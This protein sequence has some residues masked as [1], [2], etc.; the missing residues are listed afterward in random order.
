MTK[1]MKPLGP[2]MGPDSMAWSEGNATTETA[3]L[4]YLGV[5]MVGRKPRG[6]KK[7]TEK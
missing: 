2:K 5:V 6:H 4:G 7:V 3:Y 1:D